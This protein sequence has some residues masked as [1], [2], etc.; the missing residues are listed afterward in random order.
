MIS[1]VLNTI[2]IIAASV[3]IYGCGQE[4][5][6]SE[7][8]VLAIHALCNVMNNAVAVVCI[9]YADDRVEN[10]SSCQVDEKNLYA[11]RGANV[12][13]YVGVGTSATTGCHLQHRN[14]QLLGSCLMDGKNI[15]YYTSMWNAPAAQNDCVARQGNWKFPN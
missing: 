13:M 1:R 5:K 3:W 15:R 2:L 12:G 9:D 10:E 14:L 7:D 4:A 6:K 11:S 8:T